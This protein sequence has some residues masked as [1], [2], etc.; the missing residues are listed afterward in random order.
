MRTTIDIDDDVLRAL[1]RRQRDERKTLGQLVSELLA[2]A[3]ATSPRPTVD[4][5]WTTADLRPRVD[6]DDKDA[7]W[8][9]LDR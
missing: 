6:L 2:Q 4:I 8:A 5:S 9:V 1:K 7:V 3:L